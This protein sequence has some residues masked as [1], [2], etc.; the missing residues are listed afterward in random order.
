MKT[1]FTAE[2]F[3]EVFR[4]YNLAVWPSQIILYLLAIVAIVLVF[5]RTGKKVM[6]ISGILAFLWFWMGTMY[7][8]L[9]FTTIN[10]AA[11]IF[12]GIYIIQAL[13]FTWYG[14]RNMRINVIFRPDVYSFTGV[15]FVLYGLFIYPLLGNVLGHIYPE[16]P[17]F[18]LPCPT[19]IYTFGLLLLMNY[20]FPWHLL[21]FPLLWSIIG[22][23][24]AI[25]FGI[26]EDIGLLIAG[27]AGYILILI[28][29]RNL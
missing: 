2:Q 1:P 5:V 27:I 22:F 26:K 6:I 16:S 3:I 10:K 15:L 19:T 12:G 29:N 23:F 24:A 9:F 25:N 28:R 14:L 11:W 13:L 17:T 8:F 18:G 7:H 21:I 4:N 20:R